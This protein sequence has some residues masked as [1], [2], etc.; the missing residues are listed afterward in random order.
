[1]KY[2][3]RSICRFSLLL[4][5]G[6]QLV[7]VRPNQI[8]ESNEKLKYEYLREVLPSTKQRIANKRKEKR[9]TNNTTNNNGVR[10]LLHNEIEQPVKRTRTRKRGN[11]SGK[12]EQDKDI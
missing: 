1:M 11:R 5:I 9:G 6:G 4:D 8:I 12:P 10:E 2:K 7:Q 3:Y